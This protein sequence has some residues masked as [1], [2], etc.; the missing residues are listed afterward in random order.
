MDYEI[1]II[2]AGVIGLACAMKFSSLNKKCLVLERH[3]SFGWE[4]S[5][6]NSEVIHSGIYYPSDSLKAKLCVRG[7][8]SLYKWCRK[9]NIPHNRIGKYIIAVNIDESVQLDLLYEQAISN[10]VTNICYGTDKLKSD[11]PNVNFH[12][13]LWSS[14]TGIID[15][16]NLMNSFETVAIEHGCDLAYS[17]S[18]TNIEKINDG[19][20]LSVLM[21][22]N[23]YCT[24]SA[25]IVINAAGLDSDRIAE[26]AGIDTTANNYKLHFCRGH[27]FSLAPKH[28]GIVN[29][30]IYPVPNKHI[31]GL[32]IHVTLDL[33]GGI[34]LGPDTYY[35][36]EN[37]QIYNFIPG[38]QE[39]FYSAVSRYL[40]G[41]EIDDLR[42]DYTGIRPKL[43]GK[44]ESFRDFVIKEESENG[45]PGLINLIGIES[46]GLTC[47]LEIA[48]M[49]AGL[50]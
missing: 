17:H 1:V 38:L 31:A 30:L 27:Y 11:E 35:L 25:N 28:K 6:R 50:I 33:K 15:S 48:D 21:P 43:Q 49:V 14:D 5:S 40:N 34:R 29:H 46:P 32:G 18:V 41:I 3:S 36:N 24:I 7:N 26:L 4:T 47:C 8:I 20:N 13:A 39:Q 9:Y 37:T 19:Y 23:E 22:D 42:P 10:G 2:G 44:G 12:S 16:H 45:L